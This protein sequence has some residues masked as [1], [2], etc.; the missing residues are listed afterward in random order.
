MKS[1]LKFKWKTQKNIAKQ[2]SLEIIT[3]SITNINEVPTAINS[4]LSKIDVLYLPTDNII[5]SAMPLIS[6]LCFKKNIP[7]IGSEKGQVSQ[8]A[9]ATI[10]IDYYKLGFQ[11]GLMAVEVI[12]GKKP[13]ELP[14]ATSKNMEL[15]IN[16]DAVNKLNVNIPKDIDLKAT[17][18]KGGVN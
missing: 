2:F 13:S 14:I 1:I 17:K 11:T 18:I 4:L 12:E 5:T 9:L 7:I 6:N 8:G 3:S 16:E 15:V 10:G